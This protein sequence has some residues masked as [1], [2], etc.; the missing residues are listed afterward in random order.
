M[1][2]TKSGWAGMMVV[3]LCMAIAPVVVHAEPTSFLL[4]D[5]GA[6]TAAPADTGAVV[7]DTGADTSAAVDT[8]GEPD[9]GDATDE[10]VGDSEDTS[11]PWRPDSGWMPDSGWQPDSGWDSADGWGDTAAMFD[12]GD[13]TC[14]ASECAGDGGCTCSSVSGA[15]LG[16]WLLLGLPLVGLRR[17]S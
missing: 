16:G 6:D 2:G 13:G 11:A 10:P 7:V 1:F 8:A 5:T 9:I 14:L 15:A 4:G 17:R 12:T 3:A